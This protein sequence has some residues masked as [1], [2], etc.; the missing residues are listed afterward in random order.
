MISNTKRCDDCGSLPPALLFSVT[1]GRCKEQ[2]EHRRLRL[3]SA[4]E[5][6]AQLNLSYCSPS[7][8]RDI[9]DWLAEND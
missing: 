5:L 2:N 4:R 7:L 1:C 3:E 6:L 8:I 9:R